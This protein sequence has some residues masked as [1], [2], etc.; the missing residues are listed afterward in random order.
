MKEEL[1]PEM[2][3]ACNLYL[4]RKQNGMSLED[5]A[6]AVGITR[7]TLYAWRNKPAWRK[8]YKEQAVRM[9]E[10]HIGDVLEVVY[11]KACEGRNP[12][13]SE[14]YLRTVSVLNGEAVKVE[15]NNNQPDRSSEAIEREIQ[16]LKKMLED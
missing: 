16:E 4:A 11:K 1:S 6:K 10:D 5:I 13:W 15:V 8:Y 14:L 7:R 3:K 12:R 9:A 2:I